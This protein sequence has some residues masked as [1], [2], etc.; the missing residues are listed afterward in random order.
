MSTSSYLST[1]PAPRLVSVVRPARARMARTPIGDGGSTHSE[2]CAAQDEE[3]GKTRPSSSPTL[4]MDAKRSP[5][6]DGILSPGL[7][8]ELCVAYC[9]VAGDSTVTRMMR[10]VLLWWMSRP[11]SRVGSMCLTMPAETFPEGMGQL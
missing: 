1:P 9:A 11:P 8:P 2:S 4:R 6:L 10:L 7:H 5:K 3:V